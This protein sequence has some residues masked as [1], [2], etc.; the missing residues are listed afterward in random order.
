MQ[1]RYEGINIPI[2]VIR[3]V[4]EIAESGSYT[5]A[6]ERLLLSQPAISAQIKRLQSLVGGPIFDRTS[7][8][9]KPT[10]KGELILIQARRILEA[11]DQIL[12]LGGRVKD[13]QPVRVGLSNLYAEQFCAL[14]PHWTSNL[15]EPICI[16]CDESAELL[17]CLSEG[18]LD[19]ACMLRPPSN[20]LVEEWE[21][22]FVWVRAP[23]FVLS[24]GAPI[25][26]VNLLHDISSS[27]AVDALEKAGLAY[28]IQF[29]SPDLHAR[30][31]A[32]AV[33]M[34][35]MAMPAR[36]VPR[37]LVVAKDY[38]LPP[39]Q[40]PKAGICV[41]SGV[42]GAHIDALVDVLKKLSARAAASPAALDDQPTLKAGAATG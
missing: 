27:V 31:A 18:Y 9:L 4:V 35:L 23:H 7:T 1:R 3:S 21:E 19:I 17:R 8:G 30:L 15:A 38:Y 36:A 25:P 33:G 40:P 11:N 16:H 13:A 20:L 10:A 22:P 41:R 26:I 5:K 29:E 34:G 28:R 39:L 12:S 14:H 32:V 6:G 42:K 24:P 37:S 2:E